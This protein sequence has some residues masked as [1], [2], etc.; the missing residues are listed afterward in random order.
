MV[1]AGLRSTSAPYCKMIYQN[2]ELSTILEIIILFFLV[3]AHSSVYRRDN[4]QR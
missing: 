4:T 3:N 2:K 1:S